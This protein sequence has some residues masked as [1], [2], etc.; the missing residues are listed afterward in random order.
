MLPPQLG[1][2]TRSRRDWDIENLKYSTN[3]FNGANNNFTVIYSLNNNSKD[4]SA[5]AV[6][7][8]LAWL[9]ASLQLMT[10]WPVSG[11]SGSASGTDFMLKPDAA[12]IPGF[13]SVASATSTGF[14]TQSLNFWADGKTWLSNFDAPLFIIPSGWR[15]TVIEVNQLGLFQPNLLSSIV[16]LYGQYFPTR[17]NRTGQRTVKPTGLK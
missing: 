2:L 8:I 11:N 12:T 13:S 5:L 17:N 1:T 9:N 6:Y 15:L 3:T 4:G 14:P 16:F 7:G 10:A